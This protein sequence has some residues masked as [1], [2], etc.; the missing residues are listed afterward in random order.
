MATVV[1]IP[2]EVN[3]ET[4]RKRSVARARRIARRPKFEVEVYIRSLDDKISAYEAVVNDVLAGRI[5]P[6]EANAVTRAI[7]RAQT[8]G[9][10]SHV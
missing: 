2:H 9:R 5:T 8:Q 4:A 3:L 1:A 10:P 6:A 7:G